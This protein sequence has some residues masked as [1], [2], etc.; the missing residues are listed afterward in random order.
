MSDV[1]EQLHNAV[2]IDPNLDSDGD[3]FPNALE[4]LAGTDPFNSNSYPK[5]SGL[6]MSG[7]NFVM[8]MPAAPGKLYQLQSCQLTNTPLTWSNEASVLA[9]AGITNVIFPAPANLTGK[10]F[11]VMISDVESGDGLNDWEKYQLGLDP[12]NPYSNGHLDGNGQAVA[13]YQYVVS[14]IATQNVVS[15]V[16]NDP[17]TVQP[18]PGQTPTD[19]GQF[20]VSRSGFGLNSVTVHL[21]A[22]GPGTGFAVPGTDHINNLPSLVTLTPGTTSK[23]ISVTPLANTNLEVPVIAQ[24]NIQPDP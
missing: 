11:R 10:F 19:L 18:D 6:T 13:D 12:S 8:N 24:L 9:Q 15:I 22:G 4:A 7:T 17:A 5:I 1:W 3:G 2:G 21:T 16:A 20:T 14:M 23:I